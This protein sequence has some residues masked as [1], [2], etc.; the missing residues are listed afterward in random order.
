MARP[1]EHKSLS[2]VVAALVP[3]SFISYRFFCAITKKTFVT[4]RSRTRKEKLWNYGLGSQVLL[5]A[6]DAE[7]LKSTGPQ[8]F[9][10][11]VLV[12]LFIPHFSLKFLVDQ[13]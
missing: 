2:P 9:G 10:V 11:N 7:V 12:C 3:K 13:K 4:A 6:L 5:V 8:I 1:R